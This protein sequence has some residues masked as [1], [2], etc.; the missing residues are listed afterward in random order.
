MNQSKIEKVSIVAKDG[1]LS[2]TTTVTNLS[3]SEPQ[4][5]FYI[6][7]NQERIHVEW[8]TSN[9]TF[10]F[11]TNGLPGCYWVSGFATFGKELKD[12]ANS[13][14]VF[15]NSLEVTPESFPE[16]DQTVV[17]YILKSQNWNFPALY[18]PSDTKALFVLMPS[19]VDRQ[20]SSLPAFHRWTWAASGFFPGNVLC[21][22]DPT[23]ALHDDLKLGWMLGDKD[24]CATLEL[25]DF[26]TNLAKA[27]GIANDHIVIYGSSAGGFAALAM[28]A[29]IEG[30][31]AVAVNPQIDATAYVFTAQV[32]L[33]SETCFGIS[34]EEVRRQFANRVD[35]TTR[36]ASVKHS[37]AFLVQN[38]TDTHHHNKH[39][40]P[41]WESIGGNPDQEGISYADRH[42]AWVYTADGGHGPETQ[43][44]AKEIIKL[45]SL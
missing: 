38:T 5:A 42:I 9:S 37:K 27:K 32:D 16:A 13:K 15:I 19:A 35:M 39:F 2:C 4:F 29:L 34:K 40:K 3:D 6:Y 21:L 43:D 14:K 12:K 36:W 25:S 1:I 7:R 44:M 30:S 8:Y 18:Y 20:K 33:V 11:D 31:V 45:L 41:F 17:S 24:N 28:S 10:E 22:S 26:I 23:L